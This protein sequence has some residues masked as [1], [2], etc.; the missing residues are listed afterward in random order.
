MRIPLGRAAGPLSPADRFR[1]ERTI[2]VAGIGDDGQARLAASR[3]LVIG[4]G[5]LGSPVLQYLAGCGVGTI[6]ICDEDAVEFSNLPRQIVHDEAAVGEAKVTSATRRVAALSS[7][8]TV[9]PLGWATRDLLDSVRD[10]F[11][12]VLDCTDTFDAK[13]LVADWCRDTGLP[14]VWGTVIAMQWQVS[15][16]WSACP[17]ASLARSLRDLHPAPPP[18]GAIPTSRAIGV[19]G[20]VVG[21]CGS[22]MATEAVKL[23]TGAGQPLLGRVLVADAG[24]CRFSTVPFGP[25]SEEAR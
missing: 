7:A 5:G 8:T 15:V 24:A 2:A 12:L 17:A 1:H 6:G 18:E 4:A 19:L 10:D 25:A 16:F 20:P 21:E 13:Y 22:A 9:V 14:L 23:V 11:D 3:M